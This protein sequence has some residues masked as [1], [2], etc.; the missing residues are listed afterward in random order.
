MCECYST[1]KEKLSAHFQAQLPEGSVGFEL[2]LQGYVFGISDA[3]VTHRSAN[4]AVA[5]YRAPK[6]G[7]GLKKVSKST[8]VRATFCPFCGVPYDPPAEVN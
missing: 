6:K 1:V 2:E 3:G 7:G 8:F 5:R 4:N